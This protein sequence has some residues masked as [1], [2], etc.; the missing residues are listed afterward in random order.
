MKYEIHIGR[1][2]DL[3]TKEHKPKHTLIISEDQL[4][5]I[6]ELADIRRDRD[7]NTIYI[8]NEI[9]FKIIP[10]IEFNQ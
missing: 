6:K 10:V 2:Y 4:R 7:L 5:I 9:E 1:D 3:E 8:I